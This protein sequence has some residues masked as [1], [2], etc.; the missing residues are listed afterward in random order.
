M[1]FAMYAFATLLYATLVV[2]WLVLLGTPLVLASGVLVA[3]P[4]LGAKRIRRTMRR[5]VVQTGQGVL[6][7]DGLSEKPLLAERLHRNIAR[8]L[9]FAPP[10]ARPRACACVKESA[11]GY[12]GVLRVFD[13]RGHYLLREEARSI[14]AVAQRLTKTLEGFED[15]FPAR[16]GSPRPR[17]SECSGATCPQRRLHQQRRGMAA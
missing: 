6:C 14:E 4:L 10:E 15:T 11:G 12:V 5:P 7:I 3:A 8:V 2:P 13:T 9:E 1:D 17:C 16:V